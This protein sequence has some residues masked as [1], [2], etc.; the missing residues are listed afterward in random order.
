LAAVVAA[1]HLLCF[2]VQATGYTLL[3]IVGSNVICGRIWHY[4][5]T[6][7]RLVK[8]GIGAYAAYECID[9]K[10]ASYNECIK[11]YGHIKYAYRIVFLRA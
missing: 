11:R 2:A 8:S 10:T 3:F 7:E 4:P 6:L 1:H 5:H 9:I